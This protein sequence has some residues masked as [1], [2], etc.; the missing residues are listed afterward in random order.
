VRWDQLF[1]D[2]E[3]QLEAAEAQELVAEVADRTRREAA[4]I[5]LLDRLRAAL[6]SDLRLQVHGVGVVSGVLDSVGAEWAL[7][8][9]DPVSQTLVPLVAVTS[10]VGLGPRAVEAAG[11]A[12]FLRL[13]MGSA[14]RA[15]ARDRAR[16]TAWLVDGTVLTGVVDRVG[17]D[18]LEL[19]ED[20]DGCGG[21]R[22]SR[23]PVHTVPFRALAALRLG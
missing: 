21:A 11:E 15:V 19:A 20:R 8:A 10:V 13:G 9:T 3:G 2:L 16:V 22:R 18:H 17:A 5:S 14:L 6:G 7:V 12:L 4:L 1:A 23:D